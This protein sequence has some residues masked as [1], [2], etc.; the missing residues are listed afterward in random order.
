MLTEGARKIYRGRHVA[1]DR[2]V[3][4]GWARE[5]ALCC[6]GHKTWGAIKRGQLSASFSCQRS[7]M[8]SE[9]LFCLIL[10]DFQKEGLSFAYLRFG[11][12]MKASV[13]VGGCSR[14]RVHLRV[15][16]NH[17]PQFPA[18]GKECRFCRVYAIT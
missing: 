2:R 4:Q 7:F 17:N 11:H 1:R 10:T 18:G 8:E 15:A 16:I 14:V 12:V 13:T 5:Y 9:F 6:A 3:R